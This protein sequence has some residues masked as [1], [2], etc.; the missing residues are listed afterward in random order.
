MG[1]A[2]LIPDFISPFSPARVDIIKQRN[3]KGSEAQKQEAPMTETFPLS[4]MEREIILGLLEEERRELPTE[5]RRTDTM[6]VH[7]QLQERMKA[8][9][10]LIARL[11]KHAPIS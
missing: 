2:L 4:D 3:P 9:D 5:I 11:H 10:D 7:D 8:V 6:Q 1:H